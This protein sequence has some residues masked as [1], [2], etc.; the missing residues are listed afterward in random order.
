MGMAKQKNVRGCIPRILSDDND[1]TV[2]RA[3]IDGAPIIVQ[4]LETWSESS[5]TGID[6]GFK[7]SRAS[8]AKPPSN[9][10]LNLW[11]I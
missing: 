7:G 9:A 2:E 3:A 1:G 11:I 10:R 8:N 6:I 5:N 4:R